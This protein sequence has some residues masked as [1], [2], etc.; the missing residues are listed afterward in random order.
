MPNTNHLGVTGPNGYLC[1]SY[2]SGFYAPSNSCGYN[3]VNWTSTSSNGISLVI[4]NPNS[5]TGTTISN[6]KPNAMYSITGTFTCNGGNSVT[7]SLTVVTGNQCLRIIENDGN[8]LMD[9]E[10]ANKEIMS[11]NQRMNFG[12]IEIFPNPLI[13]GELLNFTT[14]DSI[15]VYKI[16]VY[17]NSGELLK[18]INNP[19]SNE[20]GYLNKGNP[21]VYHII[22]ETN[23]GLILKKLIL[24][25][26]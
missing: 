9:P 18:T 11:E 3:A 26:Q 10:F 21:E 22:F 5:I 6:F 20:I 23:K 15:R 13:R 16:S 12:D 4:S 14:N 17:S 19:K 1:K 24:N 25:K 8:G 7:R 2:T